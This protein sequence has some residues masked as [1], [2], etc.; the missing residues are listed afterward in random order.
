MSPDYQLFP[1]QK[2]GAA[3]LARSTYFLL[4]DEMGLGKSAQ[5]IAACDA[6]NAT[7]IIV[8]CPAVARANWIREFD[9]FSTTKRTGVA[10]FTSKDKPGPGVTVCSYDLLPALRKVEDADVLIADECHYL[11][12]G[13][14]K[15]T[16][17]AV[18]LAKRA[19]RAWFLSGTPAPNNVSELWVMLRLFGVYADSFGK[20]IGEF[21]H[22]YESDYGYKITGT[23]N[24]PKLRELMRPHMLRRKKEDVMKDLPP[25]NYVD[26]L[27]EPTPIDEEI[28]FVGESMWR[29]HVKEQEESLRQLL[30]LNNATKAYSTNFAN[31]LEA[32][33]PSLVTLRRYTGLSKVKGVAAM[34]RDELDTGVYNKIVIFAVHRD[35]IVAMREELKDYGAVMLFG[36]TPPAKREKAIRD[37][38][39]SPACKVFIGN[40]QAAGTA[41]TLTAAHNVVFIESDWVPGNNAQAAMRCHRIGQTRPVYVRFVAAAG[42]VDEKVTEVIRRKTRDLTKVFDE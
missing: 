36:G 27:V 15:R 21:C 20:F 8:L 40:I 37:F 5:A 32:L 12:N 16:K 35:V 9:R 13:K 4:A 7:R 23:K 3:A 26:V 18:E 17:A 24:A 42:S 28:Y 34:I 39:N 19:K 25:I 22:G 2:L 6:I 30:V 14:A 11:K 29:E 41:I 33:A 31:S 10:I 1:Y 38:Q